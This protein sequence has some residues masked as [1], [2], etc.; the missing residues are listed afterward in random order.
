MWTRI[1]ISFTGHNYVKST[2]LQQVWSAMYIRV[3]SSTAAVAL[4][5]SL[6]KPNHSPSSPALTKLSSVQ[7]DGFLLWTFFLFFDKPVA[8]DSPLLINGLKVSRSFFIWWV[9]I[10]EMGIFGHNLPQNW[11]IEMKRYGANWNI[12]H[13]WCSINWEKTCNLA[14]TWRN[15][16][17]YWPMLYWHS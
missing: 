15:P 2:I 17:R 14:K 7:R 3:W 12:R 5:S 16:Y 8:A 4:A 11:I 1:Y 6:T 10:I 13:S 9:Q